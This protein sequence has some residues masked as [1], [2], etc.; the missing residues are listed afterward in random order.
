MDGGEHIRG[1]YDPGSSF[2][3]GWTHEEPWKHP[4]DR[5]HPDDIEL[6]LGGLLLLM[7][8]S[9]LWKVYLLVATRGECGGDPGIRTREQEAAAELLGAAPLG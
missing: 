9:G 2:D 4:S 8:L 6:G 3:L 1:R 7:T 5:A